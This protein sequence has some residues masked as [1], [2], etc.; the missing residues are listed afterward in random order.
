MKETLG[1]GAYSVVYACV[2][3]TDGQRYAV[4]CLKKRDL[5]RSD[6]DSLK[7]E[8]FIM[9]R[10]NHK[11][12]VRLEGFYEDKEYYYI[13]TELVGGEDNE[14]WLELGAELFDKI[15]E[16]KF[17]NENEARSVFKT[18]VET[19]GYC[20]KLNIAHRDLKPENILVDSRT[21]D[22]KIGT[23]IDKF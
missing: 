17:Y 18:L 10:L 3:K 22:I 2:D 15:V 21:G 11:N 13:V 16:K 23:I 7:N 20:H 12:I 1:S 14:L 5:Q 9:G 8:V 4:K 19:V 6:V